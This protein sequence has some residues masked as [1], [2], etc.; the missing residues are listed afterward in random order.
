M[1]IL[2]FPSAKLFYPV[3]PCCRAVLFFICTLCCWGVLLPSVCQAASAS[4]IKKNIS[5]EKQRAVA[6]KKALR[7]LS[8]KERALFHD[9]AVIEDRVAALEDKAKAEAR[10]IEELSR[11]EVTLRKAYQKTSAEKERLR[12]DSK[13]LLTTFW[14]VFLEKQARMHFDSDATW[15]RADREATWLS[16][17]YAET[18]EKLAAVHEAEKQT[19]LALE[20]LQETR[21]KREKKSSELAELQDEL[22]KQKLTFLKDVQKIRSRELDLKEQ[23]DSIAS[24]ISSLHYKLQILDT[25]SFPKLKG[26]LPWPAKGRVV[27]GF[28]PQANPPHRGISLAL[29]PKHKVA[30]VSWGKVVHEGQLRGFGRVVILYHGKDY[31]SLY[32]FLATS[33]V[34]LGQKVEKGETLGEC[35]FYPLIKASGLYFELRFHQ[36]AINPLQWLQSMGS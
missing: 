20:R 4:E 35:G 15:A 23:L 30:A 18:G 17:L 29:A 6:K 33:R 7:A 3:S 9:L 12:E 19:S 31:Y 25:H 24:T 14:P 5:R 22:L 11:Q 21:R 10:E 32:A 1:R 27:K 8:A 16:I 34:H 36:K 13:V 26:Y 28:R 2:P